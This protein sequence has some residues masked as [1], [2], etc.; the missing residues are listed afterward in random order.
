MV[1]NSRTV[2]AVLS[3]NNRTIHT[4]PTRKSHMRTQLEKKRN[5]LKQSLNITSRA[6]ESPQVGVNG[7]GATAKKKTCFKHFNL[8]ILSN[9]WEPAHLWL[10]PCWNGQALPLMNQK[11]SHQA[12]KNQQA[13]KTK[14]NKIYIYIYI[15]WNQQARKTKKYKKKLKTSKK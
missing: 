8:E 11:Y 10:A 7:I 12:Q 5:T 3:N 6:R 9:V 4:V 1:D 13:Q 14:K 15:N 2:H